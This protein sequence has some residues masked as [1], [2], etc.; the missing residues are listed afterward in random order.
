ALACRGEPPQTDEA[1]Q[2]ADSTAGGMAGMPMMGNDSI[3]ANMKHQMTMM[4]GVS[5]DSMKALLPEHRQMAANMLAQ[6]DQQMTSMNMPADGTWKAMSDS[7]REDLVRMPNLSGAELQGF[8]TEHHRRMTQ[9]M[10]M[11]ES[12]M[13]NMRL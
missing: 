8:M 6:M 3:S 1:S 2:T 5:A 13:K 9:L 11:H 10:A 4:Q 12:M 7:I